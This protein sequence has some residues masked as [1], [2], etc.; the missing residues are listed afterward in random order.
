MSKMETNDQQRGKMKISIIVAMANGSRAIGNKGSI[1][2]IIP[3][4]MKRFKRLTL[5]HP[6]IMGKK[7][8]ESLPE[9]FRPLPDRTNI[10]M[11]NDGDLAAKGAFV[12]SSFEQAIDIA[13]GATGNDE[14]FIIGGG[15]IYAFTLPYA[16]RLYLTIVDRQVV[17]DVFFPKYEKDFA[18]VSEEKRQGFT[19]Q[20]LERK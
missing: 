20:I 4:D 17:A 16:N 1:P 5:N 6:V 13:R 8:W 10:V 2:W 19:F 14:I 18:L 9:K 3:E 15:Q 12:V 7:T 11:C